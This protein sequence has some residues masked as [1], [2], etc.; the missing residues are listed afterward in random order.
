[1]RVGLRVLTLIIFAV[2]F[3]GLISNNSLST[4]F[5]RASPPPVSSVVVDN[6]LPAPSPA[7][8]VASACSGVN[9][10]L[11]SEAAAKP[12]ATITVTATVSS[13][14]PNVIYD[15]SVSGARIVRGLGTNSIEI[16]P[17][18][19][20]RKVTT[21]VAVDAGLC[22]ASASLE[23]AVPILPP[24]DFGRLEGVVKDPQNRP[25][26]GATVTV[27][28]NNSS[29]AQ[30]TTK[31]G[32]KY[33]FAQLIVGE[34]DVEARHDQF[35]RDRKTVKIKKDRTTRQNFNLR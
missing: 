14:E 8:T 21:S 19:D 18:P 12:G 3:F 9:V 10:D 22:P 20:Q 1:M 13:A 30:E 11:S 2:Y 29:T 32:G 26:D 31:D 16:I 34:H 17:N 5:R 33:R 4:A 27:F 23:I 24:P 35:G 15:W 25:V 6:A 28:L 7:P